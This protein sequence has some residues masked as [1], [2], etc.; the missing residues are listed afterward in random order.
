MANSGKQVFT[1]SEDGDRL[2]GYVANK[3]SLSRARVQALI[4][5]GSILVDGENARKSDRLKIGQRIEVRVPAAT[6]IDLQPESIPIEI[7]YQ[8]KFIVVVN[9]PAGLV[10]HPGPGHPDGTLVNSLLYHVRD[11]SGIGGK[12]RPG[13]VHRLD[14][15]T[16]GLMVVAKTDVAHRNLSAALESR[17]VKRLYMAAS[18]GHL[19]KSPLE[20]EEPIGRDPLDRQ[21][22][23]VVES[24]RY[25]VTRFRVLERWIGAELLEV[26]LG[27]GRTH[28][29]RVHLA[30]IGHPVVGDEVYGAGWQKGM[31]GNKVGRWAREMHRRVERQFLHAWRLSFCHP[32]TG[33]L[34]KFES[35]LP[36]D[37]RECA[38]WA[39]SE[40]F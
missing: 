22:M 16:S 35:G 3:S 39:G 23:G 13:I 36:E 14:R 37:L 9:K 4:K 2:D 33:V 17:Q 38:E 12:L 6:P 1:V 11:L 31:S 24:G 7:V 25:A 10:V 40:A 20:V 19:I 27:T 34:M 18:W 21:R 29:I 15:Y 28:Q 32:D 8:D 26:S 5:D 30:H